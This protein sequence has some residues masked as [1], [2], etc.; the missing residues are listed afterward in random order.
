[1]TFI[2]VITLRSFLEFTL[3]EQ[4]ANWR[5]PWLN[6]VFTHYTFFYIAIALSI[7]VLFY[8]IT[9]QKITDVARAVM[10]SFS[11]LNIVPIIDRAFGFNNLYRPGYFIPGQYSGSLLTKY[12]TFFGPLAHF[13]V[14]PGMRTEI[15]LMMIAS[16]IYTWTVTGR[17]WRGILGGLGFYSVVFIFLILPALINQFYK[18]D[19]GSPRATTGIFIDLYLAASLGLGSFI[20]YTAEPAIFKALIKDIRLERLLYYVLLVFLGMLCCIKSYPYLT[21]GLDIF[22]GLFSLSASLVLAFLFSII[23]NNLADKKIDRISNPDRPTIAATIPE[24][25]Y[26]S[27]AWWCLAGA[28]LLAAKVS[29]RALIIISTFI[30]AYFIYSM[31]PLRLKRI[32]IL[33]KGLIGFNSLLMFMQGYVFINGTT[34]IPENIIIFFLVF[35]SLSANFIDLK[36]IQGDRAAGI[37]TLP[38]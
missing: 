15:L 19:L 13:G 3:I 31:P 24:P 38:V 29:P 9:G 2:S 27:I 34:T 1:M 26:R 36:D 7:I 33:S 17:L 18:L 30:G 22:G 20:F 6:A 23:T 21:Q 8:L 32:P 4:D 25:V 11:I 5:G 35:T 28:V 10:V 14:T 16:G 12:F 37:R